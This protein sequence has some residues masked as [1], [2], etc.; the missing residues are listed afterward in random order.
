MRAPFDGVVG[1]R[2][3]EPGEYVQP[4][5]RLMALVPLQDIYVDANFKETQLQDL[6]PGQT[7]KISVDAYPGRDIE[8]SVLSVAPASGSVFSLLP[9]DN[10]TGNFTK[11]VQRVPVRIRV[12]ASVAAEDLI[13][14]GMSVVVA[15]DTRSGTE[16]GGGALAA[17]AARRGAMSDASVDAGDPPIPP[18]RIAAF[19][20]LAVGMFMAILD[21][22]IVASSLAEIQAGLSASADEISWVQTSYLVA[23]IVM[24]PL[25]GF[26][27][28]AFS[29]RYLFAIA[30]G[31]FTLASI[32]CA[33]ATS[34]GEMIVWRALQGFIGGAMIPSVF[35]AAYTI[36]PRSRQGMIS[37]VVGLIATLAPTVGPTVGGYLTDL[38][39]WHWLFLVNVFP[40]IAV[41]VG[42]ADP[43]RLRQAESED[44]PELRLRRRRDARR[45]PRQPRIRA[46]GR[47]FERLVRR[48]D[49]RHLRGRF[50]HRRHRASSLA[51]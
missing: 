27:G 6:K 41:T 49:D 45:L 16:F 1:N 17:P 12:P 39:S 11:V 32:G 14:P 31:G 3:A 21:I 24:I 29:T 44:P 13:R 7:V 4:G 15:V 34:I 18:R 23:E 46:G 22:Q 35:A 33:T 10:A 26:L 43:R 9:P 20:V 42:D 36:F 48:P 30:A 47:A 28:R 2:A 5:T 51:R 50:G 40:G 37:A 38:F 19:V 8:G 25:T